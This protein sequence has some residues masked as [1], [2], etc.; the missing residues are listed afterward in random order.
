VT[1]RDGHGLLYKTVQA[2]ASET[3]HMILTTATALDAIQPTSQQYVTYHTG[4]LQFITKLESYQR[5]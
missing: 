1:R 4:K 5:Q 2:V 3:R